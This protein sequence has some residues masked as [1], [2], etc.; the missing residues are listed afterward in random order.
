MTHEEF[1]NLVEQMRSL[2]K[3]YS[4]LRATDPRTA[5][6]ILSKAKQVESEVD[7][8]IRAFKNPENPQQKSLFE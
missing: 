6:Q 5:G 1:I 8:Q 3:Q 2:Q 7:A 4:R